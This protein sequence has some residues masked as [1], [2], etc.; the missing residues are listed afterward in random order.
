MAD[1]KS[2]YSNIS[3]D[4]LESAVHSNPVDQG[5]YDRSKAR[6]AAH[7][8]TWV[9]RKVNLNEIVDRFVP[10]VEGFVEQH[11]EGG[12]KYDFEGER[13][14]VKCDKVAGYL[15]I[16]DKQSKSYCL[17]DGTPSK[18]NSLT[19]FKIKRREEM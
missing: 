14:I 17:L 11:S 7:N 6:E 5:R 10:S 8:D 12:V 15:R 2:A 19:H 13:Y 9:K 3:K 18:D 16:W 1:Y 4:Y